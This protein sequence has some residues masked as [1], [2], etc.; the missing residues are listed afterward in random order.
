MVTKATET[1]GNFYGLKK[2]NPM[3]GNNNSG[4]KNLITPFGRL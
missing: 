3:K 1:V 2:E 4:Y